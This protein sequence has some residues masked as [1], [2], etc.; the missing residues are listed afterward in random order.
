MKQCIKPIIFYSFRKGCFTSLEK[1]DALLKNLGA[2]I[3]KNLEPIL[4]VQ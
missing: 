1:G 3:F 4:Q 2:Y